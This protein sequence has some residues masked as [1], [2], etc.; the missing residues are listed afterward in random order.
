[1]T[2]ENLRYFVAAAEELNFKKSARLLKIS[3]QVLESRIK[4][5]GKSLKV[6]LFERDMAGIHLTK[7]GSVVLEYAKRL[8]KCEKQ[9]IHELQKVNQGILRI[10]NVGQL[11]HN[12][13]SAFIRTCRKR[14][15]ELTLEFKEL[16]IIRQHTAA[17]LGNEIDI[18]FVSPAELPNSKKVSSAL[19]L[20]CPYVV[21]MKS[22]HPLAKLRTVSL[23]A[24]ET[25][26]VLAIESADR[27][28]HARGMKEV[29]NRRGF[30]IGPIKSVDGIDSMVV[31]LA[32]GF[33]VSLLPEAVYLSKIEGITTRRVKEKG[34]DLQFQLHAVWKSP[35]VKKFIGI[36][37]QSVSKK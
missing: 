9:M 26:T 31:S 33:G 35:E 17:L 11:G 30:K 14:F 32:G 23:K 29:M 22:D 37:Q 34:E 6:S 8:L 24:L 18:G 36:L 13:L 4:R 20:D 7:P 28:L 1:M 10:G 15:P 19:L 16:D 3:P 27:D 2:L 25:Q 21:A 12:F 5:L